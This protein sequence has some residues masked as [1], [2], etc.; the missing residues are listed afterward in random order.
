MLYEQ[1]L[2]RDAVVKRA[3]RLLAG[4]PTVSAKPERSARTPQQRTTAKFD[5]MVLRLSS[6]SREK[7][8]SEFPL[9]NGLLKYA[10]ESK[11]HQESREHI[12]IANAPRLSLVLL[13]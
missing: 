5:I 9:T 10:N 1:V 6:I 12:C 7:F 13:G 4:S 2:P 8:V 3:R 11:T